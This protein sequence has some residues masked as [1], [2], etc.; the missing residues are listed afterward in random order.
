MKAERRIPGADG[1]RNMKKGKSRI[2]EEDYGSMMHEC[3]ETLEDA[4]LGTYRGDEIAAYMAMF[5]VLAAWME[6]EEGLT[7]VRA[8][9]QEQNRE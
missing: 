3:L 9:P 6:K 8:E 7:D 2:S 4:A 5:T 1:M